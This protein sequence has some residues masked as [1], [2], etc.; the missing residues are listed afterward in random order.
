MI[1]KIISSIQMMG[2]V[3]KNLLLRPFRIAKNKF[4]YFFSGG[5]VA[6]ALPGM[7]KKLP[8]LIKTKPEKAEDYYDWGSIYVAKT[9]VWTIIILLI[10]IPILYIFLLHPLL[11]SWF[12]VKDFYVADTAISTYDGRVRVYFDEKHE[13]LEFEGRLDDG[14]PIKDGTAY[15]ENGRLRYDGSF[16]EGELSGNGILYYE[17]GS[18]KYRG[19]FEKGEFSGTGMLTKEDG[20]TYSGVFTNGK[21][22]GTG[23]IRK[24]DALYYE[25]EFS[26]G[27]PEGSG[28]LY[29]PNGTVK[30]SG[31]F[32]AGVPHGMAIEYTTDGTIKYNGMFTTGLYN[33]EGVLYTDN[34]DK[35][36]SGSFEMGKYSGTGILYDDGSKLYTGEFENGLYN[37]NGTIYGEDGSV[38]TGSFTDGIISG[39]AKRTYPNGMVYEGCFADNIP[40][41]AGTLSN[42]TDSFKYTGMF[43]DGDFDF[44]RII[45]QEATAIAELFTS[46]KQRVEQ[47][48]FYL[49]DNDFGVA[50]KFIFATETS[51]ALAKEIF[52]KP[53][54]GESVLRSAADVIAPSAISAAMIDRRLPEWAENKYNVA[55]DSVKCYAAAYEKIT[56]YYWVDKNSGKLVLKSADGMITQDGISGSLG[57][58]D[59]ELSY[60][61]IA[62]LFKEVGL[63]IK[64]FESLGF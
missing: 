12:W 30:Y 42:V 50:I 21:L 40:H 35:L 18:V 25:G 37:G 7:V 11:T 51:G 36:Y 3:L 32:S 24:G 5:K 34:G 43:V 39:A 29:H 2:R 15:Y 28:K 16:A 57:T 19:G 23:T 62:E 8:K 20:M 54:C 44:S 4:T 6:N 60:D 46:L 48:C 52:M 53:L 31:A 59:I 49:E 1:K 14:K 26:D 38:T 55:S 63:D 33:G 17:D 56:V 47:D 27:V 58:A 41:G 22:E 10:L 45:G 13:L 61:E 9:L 64:D